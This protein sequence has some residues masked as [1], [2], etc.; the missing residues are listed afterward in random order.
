MSDEYLAIPH[1]EIFQL[2]TREFSGVVWAIRRDT[3]SEDMQLIVVP[4][5]FVD[6]IRQNWTGPYDWTT[7]FSKDDDWVTRVPQNKVPDY[8][9]AA[10]AFNALTGEITTY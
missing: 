8:V 9:I 6:Y 10:I 3:A 7:S 4:E 1:G 2:R 5:D